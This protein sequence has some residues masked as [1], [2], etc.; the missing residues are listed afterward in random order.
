ME[1]SF[2]ATL[3][4]C[5]AMFEL[6]LHHVTCER[7]KV[8]LTSE[9]STADGHYPG[10]FCRITNVVLRTRDRK[11]YFK[12]DN[13][14]FKHNVEVACNWNYIMWSIDKTSDH[15]I[16]CD[17]VYDS[18]YLFPIFYHYGN[19]N[20]YHLHYDT[21]MPLYHYL[22]YKKK[23]NKNTALVPGVET[24]RLEVIDWT[25]PAFDDEDKFWNRVVSILS[26]ASPDIDMLPVNLN[27]I[28]T[29]DS[30]CF[31]T[32]YFG[33][34]KIQRADEKFMKSFVMFVKNHF[35]IS[36]NQL[37]TNRVGL[38]KRSN[39]RRIRN[40][41]ELI[42]NIRKFTDADVLVFE[43]MTFQEQVQ[44][45][46]SYT[47]LIGMNG[48]GLTN[49]LY[50]PPGAVAIQM[51]PYKAQVN[52]AEF[53][54]LLKARGPYLEWHNKHEHLSVA[55][56]NG[57]HSQGD[58]IVNVKEFVTLVKEAL[59]LVNSDNHLVKSEL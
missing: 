13:S 27:L 58:T 19:S 33:T 48:A 59:K 52:F 36:H 38:I 8:W 44:A 9:I 50:L 25:T 6:W 47:V 28:T 51:V 15:T 24:K 1:T 41:E 10:K 7:S 30:I 49:A 55:N 46:Q 22:Y 42:K 57:D 23:N 12:N 37:D 26:N 35:N 31:K 21:L 16:S 18:G 39:R 4:V 53:A 29:Y 14:D 3:L 54:K 56:H 11:L 45:V 2:P 17:K 43:N 34:P 5:V 32:A 40:E 20:Y